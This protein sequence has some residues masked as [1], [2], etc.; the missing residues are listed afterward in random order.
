MICNAKD[1]KSQATVSTKLILKQSRAPWLPTF[2]YYWQGQYQGL[3][4]LSP[5]K[6]GGGCF[7]IQYSLKQYR[8]SKI[9]H[10]ISLFQ[11]ISSSNDTLNSKIY[12]NSY[13]KVQKLVQDQ[14]RPT[15]FLFLLSHMYYGVEKMPMEVK[16][17]RFLENV[18]PI[19][20]HY[21]HYLS[22]A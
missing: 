15:Q 21:I 8:K 20:I 3:L 7:L 10:S 5:Q 1:N 18:Y 22:S 19:L 9:N 14:I 17:F 4:G 6:K 16:I 11:I 13:R 12:L 2:K